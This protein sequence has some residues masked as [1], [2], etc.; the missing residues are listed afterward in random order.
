MDFVPLCLSLLFFLQGVS[1]QPQLPEGEN[2]NAT[3]I[4]PP[5]ILPSSDSIPPLSHGSKVVIAHRGASAHLPEHSLGGYRLA[6]E[7]GA[8]YIEP[9]LVSTRDGVLIAIHSC[10]LNTTTDVAEKFPNRLTFSNFM[11]KSGFWSFEFDYDEI[12]TLRLRQRLPE[13][14]TTKFDGMFRVPTLTD[15]LNLIQ[16]WNE[17]IEPARI[18]SSN[19]RA[20]RGVYAELKDVPWQD[21]DAGIDIVDLFFHHMKNNG[22]LWKRS[23]FQNLC[24][25]KRLKLHEYRLPPLVIQSFEGEALETFVSRWHEMN[26]NSPE[27]ELSIPPTV[28]LIDH[29]ECLDEKFWFQI[30]EKWREFLT[31]VGPDKECLGHRWRE[32]MERANKAGLAVHPWTFRPEIEYFGTESQF[33]SV[34][35]EMQHMFCTIGVNGKLVI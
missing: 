29:L 25:F 33:E 31:G 2:P 35:H 24:D 1:A 8:D 15:I 5:L 21:N 3:C 18:K 16:E 7:M 22:D 19:R 4:A 10:D 17:I 28:L 9:D 23:I 30:D 13:V 32:F 11:N 20:K 34:E 6:L 12:E 26:K 14:R 27:K